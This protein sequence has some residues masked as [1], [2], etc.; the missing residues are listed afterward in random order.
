MKNK[1][2]QVLRIVFL[3]NKKF[4]L[5]FG[6]ASLLLVMAVL[7]SDSESMLIHYTAYTASALGFWYLISVT[8][9]P[10]FKHIKHISRRIPIID[11]YY[12]DRTFHARISF[13]RSLFI[14]VFY[15]AFKFICGIYYRSTWFIAIA[16][17]YL[18]L[19]GIKTVILKRDIKAIR[20]SQTS[21]EI[22]E[23][24]GYRL[25]GWLLLFMDIGLSGIAIH[26]IGK[27][28]SYSYPGMMILAMAAYSFYRITIVIVRFVREKGKLGPLFSAVKYIDFCFAIVSMFTLQTAMLSSFAGGGNPRVPNTITGTVVGISI[29]GIAVLMVIRGSKQIKK[30]KL[31]D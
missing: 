12:T 11:R 24:E 21:K 17:Y 29:V 2:R 9:L 25:V 23:W 14:N 6:L 20:N 18:I 31:L 10:L 1:I 28:M 7:I 22:D 3:P 4:R 19:V 5:Y 27:N 8:L 26:V 30:L 15:A 16:A 13:Y